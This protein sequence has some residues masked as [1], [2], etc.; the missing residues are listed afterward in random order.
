MKKARTILLTLP[1]AGLFLLGSLACEKKLSEEAVQAEDAAKAQEAKVAALEQELASLR[2][3]KQAVE[4]DK[5]TVEH[6]SKS[7]E[8][9]LEKQ[10]SDAKRKAA[11]K[12]KAAQT[13]AAAPA[14]PPEAPKPVVVEVPVG[15]KVEVKLARELAT[16]KD[17]PGGAWEGSLATDISV[18]GKLVWPAGTLVRGVVTQSVAAGRL[19][20]GNGG[21]GI[22]LTEVGPCDVDAG[23]YLVSGDARGSRNAKIIGGG[24]ALGA[25]IG[26]LSDRKNKGDHALGGAALGAAAGTA[27]A[28][29]TADTV[30]KMPVD[31]VVEFTLTAPEK[32]TLK[33]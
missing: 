18:N 4:G 8:K 19:S 7:Q 13:L 11:E 24:A 3:G 14:P 29:G 12:K 26:A 27:V 21:L 32:V 17:Q 31:K 15:T 2:S 5:E 30:I 28:A 10:L 6:L 33:P 23:V 20:S 1:V 22:R 25:L 16:D 9:A